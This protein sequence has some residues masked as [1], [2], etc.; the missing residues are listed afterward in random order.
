MHRS[1]C[2][3]TCH[4]MHRSGQ[5]HNHPYR[6]TF[7]PTLLSRSLI[8]AL[9]LLPLSISSIALAQE[10]KEPA[11]QTL[12]EVVVTAARE[13]A[14]LIVETDPKRPQQPLPAHDG[15]DYLK[16]IPGFSVIRKGGS[17]GDPVFRG[18]AGSRLNILLDGENIYGGCGGRMD[19]PT[20]YV[21]PSAYDRV[22]VI[23]GPQSVRF[24]PGTVA[25][26]VQ[27]ERKRPSFTAAETAFSGS[28]VG[29]SFGRND[30]MIDAVAGSPEFYVRGI[31]TNS[32]SHDYR[33]GDGNRVHSA[34]QRWSANA[35]FG[36]TPDADTWFEFS[37]ATS[38][39]EAAYADRGMD[40]SKFKRENFGLRF[41]K[42][43]ISPVLQKVEAQ[44][45]HNYIDHVMDNYSLR[46]FSPTPMMPGPSANNP[47]RMTDG[48]R[49]VFTLFP[50]ERTELVAGFDSQYNRHRARGTKNQWQT[51]YSSQPRVTDARFSQYGLFSELTLHLTERDRLLGGLRGD[52][53]RAQ[54]ARNSGA[55]G[56]AGPVSAGEVRRD[57]LVSGFARYERDIEAQTL[58]TFTPY[59]GIGHAERFPDYWELIAQNKQSTD[60]D[61]AFSTRPEKNTQVDF[62]LLWNRKENLS[63]SFSGFYSRV[64][65]FIL[66][67]SK[68]AGKAPGA[69]VTRNIDARLWGFEAT[70]LWNFAENWKLGASL[71][72][73]R[74]DNESDGTPLAQI[75]PFES[76][77]SLTYDNQR[78]SVGGLIR[79]VAAQ[80]RVDPGRGNIAG[81]DIGPT[82]GFTTFALNGSY[83]PSK[84]ILISAGVDNLFDK[85]YAEHLDKRSTEV[86][87]YT[88]Q[89]TRINEPGR[90]L[91]IKADIEL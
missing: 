41:E 1:V 36:W 62:G 8:S 52:W 75:P 86:A 16:T 66:I 76:R 78:F 28:L 44:V 55:V 67:D 81:Q 7:R 40:G 17:D 19:P 58:G 45:Y 30:E 29:G 65:D 27:F 34:Y 43:N 10:H 84:E 48:G 47:D 3:P 79:A 50:N 89:F 20:A 80:N 13:T 71:A 25:G 11:A 59:L 61:S 90:T 70:A 53:W 23:K 9:S 72:Y 60:S 51:P 31:G 63:A 85:T 12:D 69:L 57:T 74:G 26:T 18:M 24:G 38:D 64:D 21:F 4:P 5:V 56:S 35:A 73:V 77:L 68:V 49:L 37:G 42:K 39:G 46:D 15:A 6:S 22:T 83:R 82:P 33:D 32:R 14:P 87:G 54:D 88:T 2:P 91:W